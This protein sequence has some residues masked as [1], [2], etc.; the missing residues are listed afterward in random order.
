MGMR[1]AARLSLG[2]QMPR[3]SSAQTSSYFPGSGFP[4]LPVAWLVSCTHSLQLG[5][6]HQTETWSTCAPFSLAAVHCR[7]LVWSLMGYKKAGW[8]RG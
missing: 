1:A 6:V 2:P 3:L 8:G 4:P 7:A 5:L